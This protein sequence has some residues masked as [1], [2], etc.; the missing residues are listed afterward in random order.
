MEFEEAHTMLLCLLYLPVPEFIVLMIFQQ[1]P[2]VRHIIAW[3]MV[4]EVVG[5]FF[6]YLI[7][8]RCP[9]CRKHI[10]QIYVHKNCRCHA[11]GGSLL[12]RKEIMENLP[13]QFVIDSFE[14]IDDEL[15]GGVTQ[16]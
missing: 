12:H 14:R 3:L 11:C 15:I 5:V 7:W 8:H 4:V 9:D 6:V 16:M 13:K 1:M 2:I 10:S